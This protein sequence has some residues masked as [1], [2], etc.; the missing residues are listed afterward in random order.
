MS[1]DF[2]E[3]NTYPTVVH[4]PVYEDKKEDKETCCS[5]LKVGQVWPELEQSVQNAVQ[6]LLLGSAEFET[7]GETQ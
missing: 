5:E 7:F 4:L 3:C 6:Y 1:L 2:I